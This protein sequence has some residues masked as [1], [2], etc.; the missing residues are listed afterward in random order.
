MALGY[1]GLVPGVSTLF[2]SDK[3]RDLGIRYANEDKESARAK[4]QIV[5][6][7]LPSDIPP[8]NSI[9]RMGKREISAEFTSAEATALM[10]N[11]PWKY[12]PYKNIQIKFNKDGSAEVSGIVLKDKIPGYGAYIGAPKEALDFA[13]K[14]LPANPV[15]YLKMK[16]GLKDNKVSIFEP[17]IF[18]LGRVSIPVNLFL[19]FAPPSLIGQTFAVDIGG[20]ISDL[21]KVKNKRD[22]IITYIN[23]RISSIP[24][25]YAKTASISDNKLLFDGTLAEKEATVK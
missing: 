21:S 10:N 15:F 3:P 1:L 14:Y 5:Y 20:M 24:G 4:S 25:F 6:E 13:I 7:T 9:Q 11:R 2:G 16:A 22:L 12:F 23:G 19:S 17:Q 18:E 8:Q